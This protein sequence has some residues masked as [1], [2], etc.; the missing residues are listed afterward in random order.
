[1]DF[2]HKS[3]EL[4]N[5]Q[6]AAQTVGFATPTYKNSCYTHTEEVTGPFVLSSNT[7]SPDGDGY[8]EELFIDYKMPDASFIANIRIY[9]IRGHF[10]KEICRNVALG[11]DGRLTWDGTKENN[12]RAPIGAY[13]IYIEAFNANG[14][15]YK[16]K[17]ICVIASRD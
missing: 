15:T 10:V 9:N 6:S 3:S 7:F 8:N 12:T 13:I 14:K 16:H 17:K 11:T 5:W 4:W 1:V 2:E